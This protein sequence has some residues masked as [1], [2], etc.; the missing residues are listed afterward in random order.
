MDFPSYEPEK[1][2]IDL[3]II[4]NAL[5]ANPYDFL[6]GIYGLAIFNTQEEITAISPNFDLFKNLP[7]K[8]IIVTA[9][10][11]NTDFVSRFFGPNIGINEDPVT[12]SAHCTLIPYWHKRLKKSNDSSSIIV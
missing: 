2:N 6:K 11:N 5:C 9:P 1:P 4:K 12:G 3:E 10:G 8:G 7:Y